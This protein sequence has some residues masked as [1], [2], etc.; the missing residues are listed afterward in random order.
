MVTLPAAAALFLRGDQSAFPRAAF[1]TVTRDAAI[2]RVRLAGPY[3]GADAFGVARRDALTRRVGLDLEGKGQS[4]EENAEPGWSWGLA[5]GRRT[6]LVDTPRSKALI[7]EFRGAPFTLRD[8]TIVPGRTRQDWAVL[9]FTALDGASFS[10]PGRLL[11][12]ATGL[13]ENT[14]MGWKGPEHT[15]VGRDWGRAPALVEGIGATITLTSEAARTRLWALDARGQRQTALAVR[16]AAG[17]AEI[18]IGPEARTLWYEVE[19][20]PP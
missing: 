16:D 13:A 10:A 19:V 9:T 8:L 15:T 20:G 12:T 3:L 7:G 18:T 14:A 2:D 5:D 4:V 17:R 11:I 6:V 1:A